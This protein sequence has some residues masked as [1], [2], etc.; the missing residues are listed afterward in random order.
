MIT[1]PFCTVKSADKGSIR[2][3]EM[4]V[5]DWISSSLQ[6]TVM[7]RVRRIAWKFTFLPFPYSVL[8]YRSMFEQRDRDLGDESVAR[9]SKYEAATIRG[10]NRHSVGRIDFTAFINLPNTSTRSKAWAWIEIPVSSDDL[11]PQI[12]AIKD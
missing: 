1:Y 7:V 11:V 6:R 10:I 5:C 4:V 2:I 12:E 3:R 9:L 8:Y